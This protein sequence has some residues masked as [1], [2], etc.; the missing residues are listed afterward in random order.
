VL[1]DGLVRA[2]NLPL[3]FKAVGCEALP[4]GARVKLRITGIDTLTLDLHASLVA[5]IDDA[6]P[7]AAADDTAETAE[8]ELV[9]AGPLALAIDTADEAAAPSAAAAEPPAS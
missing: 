2:D 4:R 1:K 6:P 7:A 3:F 5:R 9:E 8:D